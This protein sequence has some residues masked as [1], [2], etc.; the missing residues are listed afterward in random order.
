MSGGVGPE[1]PRRSRGIFY[2]DGVATSELDP[3]STVNP[4]PAR[5]VPGEQWERGPSNALV[6]AA[7][8]DL[9][10]DES[11]AGTTAVVVVQHGRIIAERYQPD[12]S[13]NAF[14]EGPAPDTTSD[15]TLISWSMAKSLT[16]A[17]VG[18]AVGDGLVKVDD[19]V[20]VPEWR[21][22]EKESITWQHLLNMRSGLDFVEDYVDGGISHVIDMLFATGQ[23]DV[24]AYA[25]ARPLAHPPGSHWSY[26]SG[27]TNIV[28]RALASVTGQSSSDQMRAYIKRRLFDPIGMA[29]AT[30]KF[31]EAGTFIGSSFVYATARDFARFGLLY[32]HDGWWGDRQLLPTGWV[33]HA[34]QPTPVP[35]TEAHGYGAHW[36]LWPYDGALA[37]HGY[38]G[39]RTIV[40]PDRDAVVVRL[41]KT[42]AARNEQL[43]ERLHDVIRAIPTG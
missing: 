35:D 29:S 13:P 24:A 7:V 10:T 11:V 33:D 37:C 4:R 12:S 25:A 8:D 42:N 39:Q 23:A 34:R 22:S 19:P 40:L 28:S 36:R 43:R 41:G 17:L 18:F 26:S 16:H 27:D 31:D 6:D 2:R 9:C 14:R 21:G 20:P 38:E 15:T 30:A 32:L 3:A 5:P 1:D